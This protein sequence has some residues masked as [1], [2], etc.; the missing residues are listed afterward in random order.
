VLKFWRGKHFQSRGG[1]NN[2]PNNPLRWEKNDD[3]AKEDVG[4]TAK[5]LPGKTEEAVAE[6]EMHEDKTEEDIVEV[7]DGNE[8]EMDEAMDVEGNETVVDYVVGG[9]KEVE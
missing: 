8:A 3:K 2:L 9:N 4:N 7:V 5:I 1:G 6:A